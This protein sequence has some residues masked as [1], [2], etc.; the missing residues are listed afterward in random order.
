M[1]QKTID[2]IHEK[3]PELALISVGSIEQHGPHLPIMTDW[4]IVTELGKRL[5]LDGAGD[6]LPDDDGHRHEFKTAGI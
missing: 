6:V 2:E 1:Y 4:A 3:D 5:G